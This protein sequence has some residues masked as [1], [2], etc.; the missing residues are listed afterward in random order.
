MISWKVVAPVLMIA[1]ACS[2]CRTRDMVRGD[3]YHDDAMLLIAERPFRLRVQAD[4][5][6]L[7]ELLMQYATEKLEP[8]VTLAPVEDGEA[9]WVDLTFLNSEETGTRWRPEVGMSIG[10]ST[11]GARYSGLSLGLSG[12]KP[13]FPTMVMAFK[14]DNVTRLW[15]GTT[16]VKAGDALNKKPAELARLCVDLLIDKLREDQAVAQ[17]KAAGSSE[18]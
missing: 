8:I 17:K 4:T 15:M 12:E 13:R 6:E 14:A 9:G 11:S 3:S 1:L 7:R 2:G 18:P 5:E 16:W 10:A